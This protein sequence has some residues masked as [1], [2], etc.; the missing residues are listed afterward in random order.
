MPWR[1]NRSDDDEYTPKKAKNKQKLLQSD[2][3][4]SDKEEQDNDDIPVRDEEEEVN[5]AVD[6]GTDDENEYNDKEDENDDDESDTGTTDSVVTTQR[7][8]VSKL[9]CLHKSLVCQIN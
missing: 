6:E 8:S 4:E 1:K 5:E 2:T 7:K 9:S 3:E